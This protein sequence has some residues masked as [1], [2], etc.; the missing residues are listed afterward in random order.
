MK[1]LHNEEKTEI[2]GSYN[3]DIA[4]NLMIVFEKCNSTV[5]TCK[6]DEEIN[7]WL[8]FKYII[9]LENEKRFIQDGFGN[10]AITQESKT[11]WYALSPMIRTD[12]VKL[13]NLSYLEL[14]D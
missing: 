6:S 2:T 11:H 7:E 5:S 3:A 8:E 12:F 13:I 1:C 9:T 4:S 14:M 10:N